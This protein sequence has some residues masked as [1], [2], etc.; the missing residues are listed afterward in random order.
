MSDMKSEENFKIQTFHS[1]VGIS[2]P[3]I[4]ET[5]YL[6]PQDALALATELK[7]FAK[8]CM[9]KPAIWYAARTIANG[10]A[11]NDSDEKRKPIIV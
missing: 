9:D 5:L 2:S 7:R 1:R 3:S 4:P 11:R 6:E 10:T 8:G